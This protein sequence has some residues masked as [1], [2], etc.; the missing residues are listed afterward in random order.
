MSVIFHPRY[1]WVVLKLQADV[2]SPW[3]SDIWRKLSS[4]NI[5]EVVIAYLE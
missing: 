2:S 4:Y 3:A 5:Y 1:D